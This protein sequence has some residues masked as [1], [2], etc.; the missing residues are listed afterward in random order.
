MDYS[1]S[2]QQEMLKNTARD[3]L[4]KECPKSLVREAE[5]NEKGYS[6]EL[7]KKMADLGWMGLVLPEKYGGS[8]LGLLDLTV[9]LEEMGRA[10]VPGPFLSTVACGLAILKWGTE[11]QK[12]ELLPRIARGELIVT[13]A[14]MEQDASYD[15]ADIAVRAAAEGEDFVINGKKLFVPD[16]HVAGCLLVVART[17]DGKNKEKGITLFPVDPKSKGLTYNLLGTFT[18]DR[19]C[20]VVFNN[21]R[22][23]KTN[24]LGKPNQGWQM[25]SEIVR[26]SAFLLCPAM[27]GSAQQVLELATNYAK[28][29][30]QFGRPIG[31][32]QA[33]QHK[34]ANMAVDVAGAR[35]ISYQTA[36]KLDEGIP[37]DMDMSIAKAWTSEIYRNACVEGTQIHGG[38]G[39]TQDHDMQ[40][41]YR[42]AKS[43][44][45]A[46]GDAD[47]HLELVAREMGL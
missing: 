37:C 24:V 19:L 34:C 47:Y 30:V 12:K 23:P 29:R 17:Q 21:V 39:I 18:A 20:E 42:R 1:L 26:L 33:I 25:V 38:I 31:T 22:V 43:M 44:E 27:V 36:W 4:E 14:L 10:L 40:L 5:K 3:F 41:Y 46:F 32:F 2:E 7:W 13:L 35:D 45:M 6:P 15:A 28:E 16:A 9:L 8:G 11:K